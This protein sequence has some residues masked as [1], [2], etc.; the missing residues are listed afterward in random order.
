MGQKVLLTHRMRLDPLGTLN[1]LAIVCSL[2]HLLSVTC[3]RLLLSTVPWNHH[4]SPKC[5][6]HSRRPV[7]HPLCHSR[8]FA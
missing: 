6:H 8:D 3:T 4:R 5:L 7:A 1:R 2:F